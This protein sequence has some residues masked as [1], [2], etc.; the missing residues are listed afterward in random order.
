MSERAL[1]KLTGAAKR[2][3]DDVRTMQADSR[4]LPLP[5]I[6]QVNNVMEDLDLLRHRLHEETIRRVVGPGPVPRG[7]KR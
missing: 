7:R 2:V 5:I 4:D 3:A 6:I 1:A